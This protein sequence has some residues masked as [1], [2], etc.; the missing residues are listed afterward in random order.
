MSNQVSGD[1]HAAGARTSLGVSKALKWPL[2][3][4]VTLGRLLSLSGPF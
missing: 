3:P 2:P 4:Y 1:S